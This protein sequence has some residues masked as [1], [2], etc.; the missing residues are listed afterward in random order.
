MSFA[1]PFVDIPFADF[2]GIPFFGI[3]FADLFGLFVG[4][5]LSLDRSEDL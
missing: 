3:P 1:I 5:Y 2:F 4:V